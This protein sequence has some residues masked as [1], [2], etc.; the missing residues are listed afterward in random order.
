M[1]QAQLDSLGELAPANP[2]HIWIEPTNRCNTRC[3]H[4]GHFYGKFGQDM[5]AGLYRRIADSVL[6]GVERAELI[7]YG[8]PFMAKPFWQMFDECMARGIEVYST[9]NGILLRDDERVAKIVRSNVVLCLSIDGARRETFEAIRP[10]VKWDGIL[11]TLEC[12]RRNAEAAGS[13]RRF[14]F[15]INFVA[16]RQNVADL[17]EL[18]RLAHRYGAAEI[19]VLPLG[20]ED[21][22]GEMKGQSV[23]DAPELVAPAFLEALRIGSRLGV[24]VDVPAAYWPMIL[25]GADRGRG[26]SGKTRRLWRRGQ[27]ARL[28]ARQLGLRAV[29]SRL[30]SRRE[31]RGKAGVTYCTMPWKD[32][33]FASDGTVF[34]CCIMG[35]KLGDMTQQSWEEIWNGPLY[36]NLRRTIHGWN[37]SR[38]CRECALPTGINGGDEHHHRRFFEQFRA[39][40]LTLDSTEIEFG[41]GFHALERDAD[42]RPSHVWMS[43]TGT[44]TLPKRE[45]AR[46]VRLEINSRQPVRET[47]PGRCVING[48]EVHF[49]DNTCDHL[50]FPVDALP[51]PRIELRLEMEQAHRVAPDPRELALPV[52]GIAHLA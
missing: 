10:F 32:A 41:D 33:Y 14:R 15:R 35:E 1:T 11:K 37:P 20:G 21:V 45:G 30:R 49:F 31:P 3:T 16:M 24:Q 4:C 39:V 23:N 48:R 17:P 6:E 9:S 40:P 27:L 44:L 25:G 29:L 13:E 26:L 28:K 34:P 2:T 38:V 22:F 12:I 42:G 52:R 47:N 19:F 36:R 5:D 46:F 51:G 18:V 8:E 43:R 7:G 50:H